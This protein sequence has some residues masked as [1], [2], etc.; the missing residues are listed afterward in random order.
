MKL[1]SLDG[2]VEGFYFY[3]KQGQALRIDGNEDDNGNMILHET[4]D[5]KRTSVINAKKIGNEIN[6]IL[7]NP[8]TGKELNFSVK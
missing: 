5:E 6:G 3:E 2:S 8:N 4:L 7:K 1:K